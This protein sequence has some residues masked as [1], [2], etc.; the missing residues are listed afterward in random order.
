MQEIFT[1]YKSVF[2]FSSDDLISTIIKLPRGFYPYVYT[3]DSPKTEM[4]LRKDPIGL[5]GGINLFAYVQNNPINRID[6]L[7]LWSQWHFDYT[8]EGEKLIHYGK[9]RFNQLGQLVEHS[10]KV[11]GEACGKAAKALK[12]LKNVKPDYFLRTPI[13]IISPCIIEPSLCQGQPGA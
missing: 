6:P 11:I 7:G 1:I 10:G 2:S 3:P 4:Y 5:V 8:K 9:Y 13:F 12:Y